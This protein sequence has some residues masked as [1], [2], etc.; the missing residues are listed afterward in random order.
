MYLCAG[1]WKN[2][3]KVVGTKKMRPAASPRPHE[4]RMKKNVSDALDQ[5][6]IS[7]YVRDPVPVGTRGRSGR[8]SY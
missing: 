4:V 8:V 6:A 2:N 3:N 1:E 5:K 7:V